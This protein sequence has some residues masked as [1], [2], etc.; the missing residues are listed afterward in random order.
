[1]AVSIYILAGGFFTTKPPGKPLDSCT[2]FHINQARYLSAPGFLF[3]FFFAPDFQKEDD[4][5]ATPQVFVKNKQVNKLKHFNYMER[6]GGGQF[7]WG[8]VWPNE[9]Q[10]KDGG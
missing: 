3:L 9:W 4:S 8:P 6:T 2:W 1:M 5:S 10:W 7:E